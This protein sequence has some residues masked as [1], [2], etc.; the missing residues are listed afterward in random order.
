MSKKI[1]VSGKY[2]DEGT[3]PKPFIIPSLQEWYGDKG[4][5]I[6]SSAI[7][8]IAD[9]SSK[10]TMQA[11]T[12]LQKDIKEVT[13]LHLQIADAKAQKGDICLSLKEKDRS[14]GSEGYYF[15]VSDKIKISATAY[16]GLFWGTRTLL[17][18]LSRS[19][20]IPQ[21]T[22]RDYPQF[23]VRGFVLD[24]GRKF[25]SLTFLR[26]YVKLLSYYKMNDFQIHL[27][28][29]GFN[30]FF[31]YNW[32]S[33]Y[34]AFRLE[35]E[36]FPGLTAKDGSYTKQEFRDLQ[37]LADEY[38]VNIVP[39]IDVPAHSLAFTKAVPAIGSKE[40]G[41]DHL[42]L[43]NPLTDSVI[44]QVFRE[45]LEGPHP[46]F[47]GPAV[48]IG[49]DE[50]NKKDAEAYRAFT[51]RMIKFVQSYGKEVRM[52]GGLTWSPGKT[53][54]RSKGVTIDIWSKDFSEPREM[55]R[56]GFRQIST[57]DAWLY[58][59]PAAGYYYDYLDLKKL[60][61]EWSPLV[62]V[63]NVHFK[64]GDPTIEGAAFAEWND[65]VGNGVSE[66]DV[67]DRVFPAVQV[68]SQKMWNGNKPK[69]AFDAFKDSSL[70]VGEGPGLNIRGRLPDS[71]LYFSFDKAGKQIKTV[72]ASF[73][74]GLK[75]HALLFD[76]KNSYAELLVTEA[77]YNYTVSFFINPSGNNNDNASI[78]SSPDAVLKLKQGN[79]GLMGFSRDG[80]NFS[81]NY[82]VPANVWTHIVIAGTN[83]GTDLYVNGKLQDH[84]YDHFIQ[85]HDKDS[86]KR[87][88]VETL[89]FPLQQVGG[90]N[91]KIDELKI[92]NR[93]LSETEIRNMN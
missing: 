64:A 78:F 50:Y 6:F 30:S 84:L 12:I 79:S 8:I 88:L 32:D 71:T 11:A 65:V 36:S 10:E 3:N 45:Y 16:Q 87:R 46:V 39:E 33:T 2:T 68:L 43:H 51:D 47:T 34:S 25:F 91:G 81:F 57:P 21:G 92:W 83:K 44:Q 86:T 58:I 70:L 42:D 31:G 13:G 28:D 74:K 54:V 66:K 80:Y 37:K 22:A 17:Q 63:G 1:N 20:N 14:I 29:N 82:A 59:V 49:T 15:S 26:D 24:D 85:F 23:K 53:P 55:K 76:G 41:R 7:R 62:S 75:G 77:G 61:N 18:L 56:L 69:M 72:N 5:Y 73:V 35:N 19:K 93:V 9:A 4:E 89:F 40:Y 38:G 90:F 27:N 60:Y 48:N 52:W 67:N